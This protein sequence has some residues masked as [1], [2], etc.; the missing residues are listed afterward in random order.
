[1]E[2]NNDNITIIRGILIIVTAILMFVTFGLQIFSNRTNIEIHVIIRLAIIIFSVVLT[3]IDLYLDDK[4]N[5]WIHLLWAVIWGF[6][7]YAIVAY[8]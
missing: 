1:M 5:M 4:K 8:S 2:S 7:L 6:N 3:A